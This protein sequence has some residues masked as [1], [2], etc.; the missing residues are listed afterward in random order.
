[1][2]IK[3]KETGFGVWKIVV[4][5]IAVAV[6]VGCIGVAVV[7]SDRNGVDIDGSISVEI[8]EG[9]GSSAVAQILEDNG[10]IKYPTVFKLESRLG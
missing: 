8:P 9:S 3:V 1:M 10:A 4:A 6:L 2:A 5:V 7:L